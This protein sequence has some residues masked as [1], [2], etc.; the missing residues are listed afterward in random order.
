MSCLNPLKRWVNSSKQKNPGL[1]TLG[2]S[3]GCIFTW[4]HPTSKA[5]T[6]ASEAC[7]LIAKANAWAF[8]VRTQ[9]VHTQLTHIQLTPHTTCPH[10][11]YLH[12]TCPHT[13]YSHT[14][15]PHTTC[16]HTTCPHTT[17]SRLLCVAGVA[18]GD[19]HLRA[20]GQ[21]QRR[22]GRGTDG[23]PEP[24]YTAKRT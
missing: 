18:L 14:T 8:S 12:T 20:K 13:T 10:T 21:K 24:T 9:L 15:C 17:Y 22:G 19:I 16:P 4:T 5:N 2:F 7:R 6:Q 11:T 3:S 23:P 1:W